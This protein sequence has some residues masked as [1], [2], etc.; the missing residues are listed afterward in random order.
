MCEY[1]AHALFPLVCPNCTSLRYNYSCVPPHTGYDVIID[2]D[3]KPWLLEVNASP[4]LSANTKEVLYVI[5]I[6]F[7]FSHL[8][9]CISYEQRPILSRVAPV[10]ALLLSA[11]V[12]DMGVSV[13]PSLFACVLPATKI[14]TLMS[15]H[16]HTAGLRDEV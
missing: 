3:L 8:H 13:C 1:C 10:H 2:Q 16:V 15:L 9:A 5:S 4:S 11:L 14:H 6:V 7:I 12:V